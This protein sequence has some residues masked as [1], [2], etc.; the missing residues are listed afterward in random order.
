[1]NPH[2]NRSDSLIVRPMQ[3]RFDFQ[4]TDSLVRKRVDADTSVVCRTRPSDM[5]RQCD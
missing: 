2:D 4:V 1:V 3:I 5:K